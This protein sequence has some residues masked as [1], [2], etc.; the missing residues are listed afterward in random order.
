ME[1]ETKKGVIR[2]FIREI[3]GIAILGLILFLSSGQM[4]WLSAWIVVGIYS[5]WVLATALLLI[6]KD[7]D[8]LAERATKNKDGKTWDSII[9]GIFGLLTT[10]KYIIAGLHIRYA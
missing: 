2:W 7:P 10:V 9:M 1:P 4:T 8:L 5:I 6:P 3:L